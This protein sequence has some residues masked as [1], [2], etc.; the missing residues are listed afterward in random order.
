MKK[1]VY[2]FVLFPGS[3]GTPKRVQLSKKAVKIGLISFL[4][5]FVVFVSS[6]VY[7]TKEYLQ[8][9]DDQVEVAELR[10][11]GK[12]QKVQIERFRQQVRNFETEMSRLERFEKKLRVIT[13]LEK[14]SNVDEGNWGVG[15]PYGLSSHSFTSSLEKESQSIVDRLSGDLNILTNQVKMRQISFQE[16]DEFLKNQQ[17]LL[18]STPAIWP[19]RGWVT[20]NFGFRKSPFTG[21]PEKHEGLD[22]AARMGSEIHSTA[23]G[24]VVVSGREHGY[25]NMIEIDHGYGVITRYGHNSKNLVNVGDAVKR[26]QTIALVGNTGRSTGP[27]VHY[28][29]IVNGIPVNPNNYILEE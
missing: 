25:G 1:E 4:V 16:L 26:G 20:S 28:E 6:S 22:I 5:L 24:K 10:R 18:I 13:A 9:R 21:L 23:D 27:H 17:S 11:E 8:F 12:I 7:F 3:T 14:S 15:G 29:V 19:T 2:T